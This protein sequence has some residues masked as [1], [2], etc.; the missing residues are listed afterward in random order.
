MVGSQHLQ[1]LFYN[2]N[3]MKNSRSVIAKL[4]LIAG[5]V[6]ALYFL[7]SI[8]EGF[9]VPTVVDLY[10]TRAANGSP[11]L[12]KSSNPGVTAQNANNTGDTGGSIRLNIAS[13]LG[14]LKDYT[15]MTW[16]SPPRLNTNSPIPPPQWRLIT[17]APTSTATNTVT[18][19]AK[20]DRASNA[21]RIEASIS[22]R[23]KLLH[24]PVGSP[25]AYTA[26]VLASSTT[27]ARLPLTHTLST[28]NIKG[29]DTATFGLIA[30]EPGDASNSNAK[31]RVQLTF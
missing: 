2:I 19:C 28:I 23:D 14:I 12:V 4:L 10:F 6:V 7:N 11:V 26:T 25:C 20:L 9:Q 1:L 16:K 22:G 30:T 13:S 29:L 8:D 15:G 5:I 21:L 24:K 17:I 3:R 31:M 18:S 27:E